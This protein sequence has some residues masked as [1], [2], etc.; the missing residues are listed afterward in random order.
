MPVLKQ[1]CLELLILLGF[2]WQF[3]YSNSSADGIIHCL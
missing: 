1:I 3:P 2:F